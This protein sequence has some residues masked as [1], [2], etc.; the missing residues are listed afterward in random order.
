MRHLA[1]V[2]LPQ[3]VSCK[4]ALA[5]RAEVATHAADIFVIHKAS[6]QLCMASHHYGINHTTME[7]HCLAVAAMMAAAL[8]HGI[9]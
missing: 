8:S 2:V 5:A 7:L 6:P 1:L 3:W 9:V 4:D